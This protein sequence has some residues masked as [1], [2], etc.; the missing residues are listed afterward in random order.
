MSRPQRRYGSQDRCETHRPTP[1]CSRDVAHKGVW[2]LQ[3]QHSP[4]LLARGAGCAHVCTLFNP[5]VG[6]CHPLTG[7]DSSGPERSQAASGLHH[8]HLR[9]CMS[10][11]LPTSARV[12][13]KPQYNSESCACVLTVQ[14]RILRATTA[15]TTADFGSAVGE[16]ARF[17]REPDRMAANESKLGGVCV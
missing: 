15:S 12:M 8:R 1:S 17:S 11:T 14:R 5:Y 6:S 16:R 13:T 9:R 3:A 4:P 10:A 2:S 7:G